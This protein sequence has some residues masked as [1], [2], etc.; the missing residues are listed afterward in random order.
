MRVTGAN[1]LRLAGRAISSQRV[2]Y[3]RFLENRE[4]ANGLE[5]PAYAP[6]ISINAHVQPVETKELAALGLQLDGEFVRIWGQ[7]YI[8]TLGRASS[9]DV[10]VWGGKDYKI[11]S[12]IDWYGQDGWGRGIA[13]RVSN[14]G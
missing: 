14:A 13:A 7:L 12:R 9:S 5:V 6:E 3:R 2:G 8:K 11:I 1:L 10:F 4:L